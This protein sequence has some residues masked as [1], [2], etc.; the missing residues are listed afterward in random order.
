MFDLNAVQSAIR[1]LGFDAW[2]FYDFRGSNTLAQRILGL[3]D[4]GMNSRRFF[5][6]VPAKGSPRKLVHRIE[7]KALDH[8]PGEKTVYLKWQELEAG[9]RELASPPPSSSCAPCG[10]SL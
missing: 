4:K 1:E 9:V 2:L 6:L 10:S 5:Y 7:S 8:L 3:T